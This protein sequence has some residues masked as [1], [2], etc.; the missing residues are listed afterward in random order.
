MSNIYVPVDFSDL[1]K[2]LFPEEKVIYSTLAEAELRGGS[3]YTGRGIKQYKTKWITHL[4]FT[5]RGLAIHLKSKSGDIPF[6]SPLYN[7]GFLLKN[8]IVNTNFKEPFRGGITIG[9]VTITLNPIIN[10]DMESAKDFKRRKKEFKK[11]VKPYML[12]QQLELVKFLWDFF[13]R[14]PEAK[15]VDYVSEA[16]YPCVE[17]GYKAFKSFWKKG[18][19]LQRYIDMINKKFEKL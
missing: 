2:N 3:T 16:E 8:L 17:A 5:E 9:G 19:P 18:T 7:T 1:R 13:E 12:Q 4:L 10:K 14:K 11:T 15:Y 6:Y